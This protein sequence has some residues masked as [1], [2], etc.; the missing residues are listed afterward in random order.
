MVKFT[1]KRK[2]DKQSTVAAKLDKVL[3]EAEVINKTVKLNSID[4]VSFINLF[5][6]ITPATVVSESKKFKEQFNE[7]H[8]LPYVK[9][10]NVQLETNVSNVLYAKELLFHF[11]RVINTSTNDDNIKTVFNGIIASF[12]NTLDTLSNKIIKQRLF[13]E[14]EN[15]MANINHIQNAVINIYNKVL[16]YAKPTETQTSNN[17]KQMLN[18]ITLK[19]LAK[20]TIKSVYESN[21]VYEYSIQK[22]FKDD[23]VVV[24][25]EQAENQIQT[26]QKFYLLLSEL[27]R[28]IDQM[29]GTKQTLELTTASR[30]NKLSQYP[31]NEWKLVQERLISVVREASKAFIKNL[32]SRDNQKLTTGSMDNIINLPSGKQVYVDDTVRDLL[33]VIRDTMAPHLRAAYS[34][35]VHDMFKELSIDSIDSTPKLSYYIITLKELEKM[36]DDGIDN[37]LEV[38]TTR[39]VSIRD[40]IKPKVNKAERE[41]KKILTRLDLID[42]NVEDIPNEQSVHSTTRITDTDMD[43]YLNQVF[44]EEPITQSPME[45]NDYLESLP[46][47]NNYQHVVFQAL[48]SIRIGHGNTIP[49]ETYKRL[50]KKSSSPIIIAFFTGFFMS[51][52]TYGDYPETIKSATRESVDNWLNT[53]ADKGMFFREHVKFVYKMITMGYMHFNSTTGLIDFTKSAADATPIIQKHKQV[54]DT[55]YAKMMEPVVIYPVEKASYVEC[56]HS[57]ITQQLTELYDSLS[58]NPNSTAIISQIAQVQN[59]LDTCKLQT[60]S[61]IICKHCGEKLESILSTAENFG[62]FEERMMSGQLQA[63]YAHEL[64]ESE[65]EIRLDLINQYIPIL[66]QTVGIKIVRVLNELDNNINVVS[67]NALDSIKT[68]I[69]QILSNDTHTFRNNAT[70]LSKELINSTIS[71]NPVKTQL[72]HDTLKMICIIYIC[73]LASIRK[74]PV[75]IQNIYASINSIKQI[76]APNN[77]QV[78]TRLNYTRIVYNIAVQLVNDFTNN[79]NAEV[80]DIVITDSN[81]PENRRLIIT[82]DFGLGKTINAKEL[83]AIVSDAQKNRKK[84]VRKTKTSTKSVAPAESIINEFMEKYNDLL[85]KTSQ[86]LVTMGLYDTI[87]LM[88]LDKETAININI[89]EPEYRE[90]YKRIINKDLSLP[91]NDHTKLKF[92]MLTL[93]NAKYNDTRNTML[94]LELLR[95]LANASNIFAGNQVNALLFNNQLYVES[96]NGTMVSKIDI[97][98]TLSAFLQ[99][100][101]SNIQLYS[102][103]QLLSSKKIHKFIIDTIEP[104]MTNIGNDLLKEVSKEHE[105]HLKLQKFQESYT[106]VIYVCPYCS[107]TDSKNVSMSMHITDKHNVTSRDNLRIIRP[108]EHKNHTDCPYCNF[109]APTTTKVIEHIKST[110]MNITQSNNILNTLHKNML[111]VHLEYIYTHFKLVSLGSVQKI[112]IVSREIPRGNLYNDAIEEATTID[113]HINSY[114]IYST[115]CD[116][117][118]E[119]STMEH[120]FDKYKVCKFCKRTPAKIQEHGLNHTTDRVY[121]LVN[122]VNNTIKRI[123]S[124]YYLLEPTMLMRNGGTRSGTLEQLLPESRKWEQLRELD[125]N[126]PITTINVV[127]N[128]INEYIRVMRQYFTGTDEEYDKLTLL[129]INNLDDAVYNNKKI[130]VSSYVYDSNNLKNISNLYPNLTTVARNDIFGSDNVLAIDSQLK[131]ETDPKKSIKLLS[132]LNA[133]IHNSAKDYFMR[134]SNLNNISSFVDECTTILGRENE[135]GKYKQII[136]NLENK[137][138][139][140]KIVPKTLIKQLLRLVTQ[141]PDSYRDSSYNM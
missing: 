39:L 141:H 106:N 52:P 140:T 117:R 104:F 68:S 75:E 122:H 96:S 64:Q 25:G 71:N 34:M 89:S 91:T 44:Y 94:K 3:T 27:V 98:S 4:I 11:N 113:A 67:E 42:E 135:A 133:E 1:A 50:A 110:H 66:L 61:A 114:E 6:T 112:E 76:F 31:K 10:T 130:P 105:K 35:L 26:I 30:K 123:V 37:I 84:Q 102:T 33:V 65:D 107:Y 63:T 62:D 9:L 59:D 95:V 57:G 80:D 125:N 73:S 55:V 93:L 17:L 132:Q 79:I 118:M 131:Q 101:R 12:N 45:I 20:E 21:D 58:L 92:S 82:Q 36:L 87:A 40:V 18:H 116:Q 38:L 54:V 90:L 83:Q 136:R 48:K 19:I 85:V 127:V 88:I 72:M 97:V 22:L 53:R 99:K 126:L 5:D 60:D 77:Y 29:P 16:I 81:V 46:L 115:Y 108:Q 51:H 15:E 47:T 23:Q 109:Q 103:E 13:I 56:T 74:T 128:K 69:N 41:A 100:S 124:E 134:L 137:G 139:N 2:G 120:S 86:P 49:L 119:Y 138:P 78:D 7:N 111:Q 43:A 32:L 70:R 24:T 129:S 121:R 14:N 8:I 28:R